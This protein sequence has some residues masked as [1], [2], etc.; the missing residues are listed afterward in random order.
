MALGNSTGVYFGISL[1]QGFA[2]IPSSV[3][4]TQ[5]LLAWSDGGKSAEKE[6]FE[7]VYQGC[8]AWHIGT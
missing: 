2:M 5:L 6:L 1:N 4:V 7:R 3:E 8:V